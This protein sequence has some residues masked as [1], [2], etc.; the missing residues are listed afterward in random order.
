MSYVNELWLMSSGFSLTQAIAPETNADG[1]PTT[2]V[3][4][5]VSGNYTTVKS[6]AAAPSRS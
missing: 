5:W 3:P 2:S 1:S 4:F 6:S